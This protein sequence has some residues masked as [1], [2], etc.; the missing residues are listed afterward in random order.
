VQKKHVS[1]DIKN[2][3]EFG[4]LLEGPKI[5]RSKIYR[6]NY[7]FGWKGTITNHQKNL[8]SRLSLITGGLANDI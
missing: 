1:R 6:L 7:L 2:I 3:I 4:L 8:S 5:G